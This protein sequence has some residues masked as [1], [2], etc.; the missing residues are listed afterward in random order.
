MARCPN[1]GK[2]VPLEALDPEYD[3]LEIDDE[4]HITGEVR[5][6]LACAECSEELKEANFEI[7]EEPNA[8][9]REHLESPGEHELSVEM[10]CIETTERYSS[11][12]SPRYQKHFY[13]YEATIIVTCA[14]CPDWEGATVTVNDDMQAS[15]FDDLV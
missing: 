4:G 11:A 13:G 1:E 12:K 7:S 10:D 15:Y 8:A 3:G 9:I 14:K 5:L 2:F 6:A